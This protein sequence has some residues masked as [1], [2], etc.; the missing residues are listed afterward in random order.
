MKPTLGILLNLGDSFSSY[1]K[2]GR[3]IHWFNNYLKHYPKYFRRPLVFSYAQEKN[4]FPKLIN[5]LPNPTGLPRFFYT[6]LMPLLYCRQFKSCQVL[7]VKQILGIWPALIAKAFW[8]IPVVATYGYDYTHFARKEGRWL[9]L[10]FIKLTEYVGLK[11]STR[12]I[13]TN[14]Q[15]L[16]KVSQLI[17][18]KKIVLLPNGVNIKIF[19][20][21]FKTSRSVINIVSVGR[22]VY[23]KNFTSLIVAVAG[24]KTSQPVRLTILGRGPLEKKLKQ[25]ASNLKVKLR[26]IK[27]LPHDQVPKLLQ[28]ADIFCL[29]SHHEGS[30]KALLEAMA[31]SLPC[32]VT[33]K[34][35]S[36]FIITHQRDGLLVKNNP[37]SL[38]AAIQSFINS[39]SLRKDLGTQARQTILKRFNNQKIIN[40]EI[41]LLK[42]L[43]HES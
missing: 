22:L 18:K 33:D 7:R 43:I 25:Q 16:Q 34:D 21:K 41:N 32:V 13:V 30:P 17:P 3:H 31:C 11:L 28:S 36:R 15:M 10:P 42:S 35:F 23:Q 38:T 6:F 37:Q 20:P 39:P 19:K 4:P 29:A 1:Q 5:L 12:V 14:S 2:S 9:F 8:K 24:L 27:S 26:H 40:Q